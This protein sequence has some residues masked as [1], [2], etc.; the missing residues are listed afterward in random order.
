MRSIALPFVA[1][2]GAPQCGPLSHLAR[3]QTPCVCLI[4][5]NHVLFNFWQE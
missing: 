1:I 5:A 2:V 4:F 3:P